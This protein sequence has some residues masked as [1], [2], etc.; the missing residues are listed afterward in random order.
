MPLTESE[1]QSLRHHLG[2]GNITTGAYPYTPDGFYE[3]FTSVISP[4]LQ[5]GAETT[6]ATATTAAATTTIVVVS[7]TGIVT[8][9]RLVIDVGENAEIVVARSV[10]G[11]SVTAYFAKAHTGTYPVCVE[12]GVTRLR[13]LLQRADAAWEALT[14]G[15]MFSTAGVKKVDE[16]EFFDP[17]SGGAS[18]QL[19]GTRKAYETVVWEIS[20][21]VRVLPRWSSER[22]A[23]TVT[24]PY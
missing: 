9:A 23:R 17:K 11:T 13:M 5:T 10:S 7:A 21:L 2:Y 24:E 19:T 15:K 8:H 4:N 6:S 14:S 1:V 16:I 3:L 12:S 22:S 20:S 18:A